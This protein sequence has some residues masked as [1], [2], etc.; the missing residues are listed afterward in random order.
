MFSGNAVSMAGINDP[1]DCARGIAHL[2]EMAALVYVVRVS[3][4][5]RKKDKGEDTLNLHMQT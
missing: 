3:P 1:G 2:I 4:E 5:G